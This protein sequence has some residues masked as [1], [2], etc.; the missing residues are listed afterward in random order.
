M[1][2]EKEE[3]ANLGLATTEK[4]IRELITRFKLDAI[5]STVE[6]SLNIDRALT[7]AILLGGLSSMQKEYRTV[8]HG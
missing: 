1:I 5:E 7:L 8:D 4:L 2:E 6:C 3:K